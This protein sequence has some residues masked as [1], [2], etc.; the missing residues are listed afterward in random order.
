MK[1]KYLLYPLGI[2]I[3]T[4]L[5]I[6]SLITGKKIDFGDDDWAYRL[7]YMKS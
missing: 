4:I 7:P 6:Y 3:G 1:L 2:L 5:A